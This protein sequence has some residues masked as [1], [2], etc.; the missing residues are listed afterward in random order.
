[1]GI[2][3]TVA[4]N[5]RAH[6]KRSNLSQEE[7]AKIARMQ[8]QSVNHIENRPQNLT[9]EAVETIARA[10]D[11]PPHFLLMDHGTQAGAGRA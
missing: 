5:I 10:L 4:K 11:V 9:L 3:E 8:V 2:K 1:V 6:R 7:L